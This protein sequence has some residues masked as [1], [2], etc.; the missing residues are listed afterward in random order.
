MS[1]RQR[2]DEFDREIR[3]HLELETARLIEEGMT[4]AAARAAARRSFGNVTRVRERYYEARRVP[5]IDHLRQDIRCAARNLRRYPV[6]AAVA[7]GSLA[8]GIGATTVTLTIRDVLFRKPPPLYAD[9]GALSRVQVG[10]PDRMI[11]PIGS[12]VPAAV[13]RAWTDT[14]AGVAA[15][16]PLRGAHEVRVA[17]R[18]D[19]LPVREVTPQLFELLGVRPA[20]GAT[21]SGA[22][23]EGLQP[24]VLSHRLWQ[25][26][27]DAR[28]DAIGAA[29]WIDNRPFTVVGVLPERFWFSE[30]NSPVWTRLDTGT[31]A[32]DD[33]LE[34]VARRPPDVTPSTLAARLSVGLDAYAHTLPAAQRRLRLQISGIEGT[35]AGRQMSFALPYLLGTSVLLT[36]LI[37]CANVAILMIAQWTAREHEI[38]IRA[39]IGA[40]RG[41]IVRGLLTE[42]VLVAVAGGTLGVLATYAL[43]AWVLQRGGLDSAFFDLSIDTRILLQAA[44]ITLGA[45]IA[46]GVAPALYETRRLQANPLR[47]MAASDRVRQRWRHALVVV[48]ITVTVALLVVTSALVDGYLQ[49]RSAD[50]GFDP[51]PLMTVY[52]ENQGGVPV[53]PILE[54]IGR[55]RGVAAV[56][57][58]TSAPYTGSSRPVRV[59]MDAV[60]SN[61]VAAARSIV[62]AQFFATLGVPLRAGRPFSAHDSPATRTAIVNETLARRL[63]TG[64][65]PIGARVWID[66]DG[67]DVIGVV[68]DYANNAMQVRIASPKIFLAM[69]EAA[70]TVKAV[71][72]LVRAA[73]DPAPLLR[74]IRRK[75]QDAAAGTTAPR[76]YTFD[77]FVVVMGQEMLVGTAPLLP[78]VAIGTLLTASGIYGVLAFAI[79]RRSRELAVRVAIGATSRDIVTLIA[80]QSARIVC[81][82]GIAGLAATFAL[83]RIVRAAGGAGSIF[84]PPG[85]VFIAPALI[86]VVIATM[87]TWLPSR[88]AA[89]IN[90]SVLLRTV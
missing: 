70:P 5:W 74:T 48:E 24:A 75:A 25:Q 29:L 62:T 63:F 7:I 36:L 2:D 38:A 41:R 34:V 76:A 88:R 26:L 67:Y 55:T 28:A 52:V 16:R 72:V 22:Q 13:Y 53:G 90:P 47:T 83:T 64:P 35:P 58:A 33:E 6:A 54:A 66:G 51:H 31:L 11:M 27:F 57:A 8:G 61:P 87:A 86:I 10:T 82:G 17:D 40:S 81:A 4:P 69:P 44:A 84:D 15:S 43:R 23:T 12:Y 20:L 89:R 37:A 78:L 79:A 1:T 32:P 3:E 56:A 42:S 85:H 59:A 77:Q 45:G 39:S 21:L 71:Y 73:G 49:A 46:A 19:N 9:P 80:A 14:M 68:A 18:T 65:A 60:G 50:M 30:M